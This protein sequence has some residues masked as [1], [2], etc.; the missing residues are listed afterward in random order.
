MN[1]AE[2]IRRARKER[3][4][5]QEVV[6]QRAGLSLRAYRSLESGEAVDP[7]L[8]TLTRIAEDGFGLPVEALMH[9]EYIEQFVGDPAMEKWLAE[10]VDA[11][12]IE[13][14]DAHLDDLLKKTSA[15]GWKKLYAFLEPKLADMRVGDEPLRLYSAG[16]EWLPYTPA[17]SDTKDVLVLPL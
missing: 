8:S 10:Q 1:L 2:R 6:A 5:S 17:K 15:N 13:I 7:H 3:Q 4:L 11:G 16:V 9:D 14:D 12:L